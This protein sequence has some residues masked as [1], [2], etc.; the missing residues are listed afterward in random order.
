MLVI[1]QLVD[2][3]LKEFDNDGLRRPHT[4]P[5]IVDEVTIED[6]F[7][8]YFTVGDL[9]CPQLCQVHDQEIFDQLPH[10]LGRL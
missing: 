4:R 6:H 9:V 1:K 3:H 8:E 2:L 10:L 7:G 5:C